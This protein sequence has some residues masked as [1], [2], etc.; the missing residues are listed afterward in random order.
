MI[1]EKS[2]KAR[3]KTLGPVDDVDAV[4]AAGLPALRTGAEGGEWFAVKAPRKD[5]GANNTVRNAELDAA[6]T[7]NFGKD[8]TESDDAP[9]VALKAIA[10]AV[11]AEGSAGED[12]QVGLGDGEYEFQFATPKKGGVTQIRFR[13][14]SAADA[15]PEA[16]AEDA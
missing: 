12:R 14:P 5:D 15:E 1:P 10:R 3:V 16:E 4:F 13:D 11:L 8:G 7:A 6:L 9:T 2:I